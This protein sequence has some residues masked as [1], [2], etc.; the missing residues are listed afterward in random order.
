MLDS[1]P[2]KMLNYLLINDIFFKAMKN[3]NFKRDRS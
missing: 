1:I 2:H 3:E